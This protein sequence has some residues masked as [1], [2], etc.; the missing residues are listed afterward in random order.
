L[1]VANQYPSAGRLMV[2]EYVAED[3]ARY[4]PLPE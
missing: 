3:E 2:S 1:A 4:V